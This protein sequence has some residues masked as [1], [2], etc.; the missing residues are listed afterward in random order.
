MPDVQDLPLGPGV[1]LIA[2]DANGLAALDKPAGILSH[3]NDRADEP[4]SLLHARYVRDGE[5]YEWTSQERSP[6]TGNGTPDAPPRRL[7]LLNRL[8]SATSGAILVC[9]DGD[10]AREI[11]ALF[12][13]KQIRKVYH[14]LVFGI[15]SQARQVWRDRLAV[16][17][18]GGVIRTGTRGNIPSEAHMTVLRQQRSGPF[19][20]ALLEL[21]PRTGRSHQLR[22]QCASRHLPIVGDATYGDFAANRA[23]AK[24]HGLKRLCL[25]SHET[26]FDYEWRGRTHTFRATA[27]T[28]PEFLRLL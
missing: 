24:K 20:L 21:E 13:R 10:L 23:I 14:A 2:H 22:V 4:R 3:P 18:K 9:T 11:R 5:Y 15:P 6:E 12:L 26:A 1:R 7:W 27:P 28:P 25:H 19:P 17:K 16:Q 8:D